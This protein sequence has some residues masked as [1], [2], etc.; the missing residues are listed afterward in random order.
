VNRFQQGSLLKLQRK[1]RPDVW[2]FRWYDN[3]SGKRTYKK[4]IIGNVA[5]LRNRREAER[6]VVALRS[7][8]N[9]DAGT[10]Q[11]ICDLAAHYRVHELTQEKKSFSTIDNH[12]HLFKR[13][14]EP[15]W[16]SHRLGAVRTM[17]VEDWL[18]SLP[19]APSSRAKL[20]CVLSTLYNHAIRHE[21]LTFNPI[22]RVRTSQ[23]RLRDKD[24]LTPEEFQQLVKQLSVRERAMVLLIGSTGLRRSEMI[25][26]TWSDL[27]VRAMEVNV[28]RSCVRNRIGK[29]K[30][31][32]SCRPVP[33]HPLVLNALLEWRAKSPY[34]TDLDFLFPSVRFK[35]NKPLSP[36]SILEK[37]VRPALAR[38]GVVGKHIGWHSFRHSLATNLR[39]LGVDIKVA[40]ELMRHS[41]CRTTLD[42]YTRA[43]DQ[44]K[45]EAS[46]KVVELMLPLEVQKLEHPSAPSGDETAPRRCRQISKNKGVYWWT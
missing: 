40:Q 43:V 19:L 29:T 17:E 15:R 26:L 39:S 13:Y 37:S 20:K 34:S 27:N 30:T 2:V 21:W 41:S 42:V 23:K 22:S 38:I 32:S 35:G 25:A 14:I 31:E 11:N 28:L 8:I 24:V 44:Q 10:P 33:L 46:L 7:S 5:Q 6:A 18:H 1:S 4:R 16:G 12:R 3:T 36:D 45:R 9:V